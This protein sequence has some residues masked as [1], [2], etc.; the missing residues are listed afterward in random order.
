MERLRLAR[1]EDQAEHIGFSRPALYS[2]LSGGTPG[3]KFIAAC[4]AKYDGP[5]EELF[6]V[7]S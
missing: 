5:F 4:M 6:E 7:A 1:V 2:I 3:E